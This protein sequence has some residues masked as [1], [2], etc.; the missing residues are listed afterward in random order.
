MILRIIHFFLSV[1]VG[2]AFLR[3]FYIPGARSHPRD[4]ERVS[5]HVTL[6]GLTSRWSLL[7]PD[8][9]Q[10]AERVQRNCWKRW[11]QGGAWEDT[12]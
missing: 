9:V 8:V 7:V 4:S 2:V 5:F 10:A 12:V 3:A 1:K 11:P 6:Q